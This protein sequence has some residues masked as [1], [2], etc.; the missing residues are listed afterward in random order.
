MKRFQVAL[1]VFLN[2]A[3]LIIGLSQNLLYSQIKKVG[4]PA[5]ENAPILTVEI[6]AKKYAFTPSKVELPANTLVRINLTSLDTEHGF[7]IES[8]PHSCLTFKPGK[9]GTVEL[10][11][12]KKGEFAFSCCH[13]CGLGHSKMK[14]VL[15]VK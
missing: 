12:D 14:G 10:Y 1:V 7:E 4:N 15:V 5:P 9:T 8:Y 2:F 11:T 3:L 13:L 6:S